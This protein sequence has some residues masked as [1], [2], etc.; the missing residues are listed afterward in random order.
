MKKLNIEIE[1]HGCKLNFADS[2]SIAKKFYS[3]GHNVFGDNEIGHRDIYILN[4]CTVTHVADSKARQSIRKVKRSNPEAVTIMTGCYAERD[5]D[6]IKEINEV[7]LVITN[8][9]KKDILKKVYDYFNEELVEIPALDTYPLIGRSRAS[10]KIQEGCNQICSYCIIPY[11]RGREKSVEPNEIISKINNASRNNIKEVVLT[12]TQLG[13]YGFDLKNT[14][15]KELIKQVLIK[16]SIERIR[17]SSLQP[18]EID[19]ELLD[20]WKSNDRLCPH[21]HLPLQSGSDQILKKMRRR[22]SSE[23]FIQI[24]SLIKKYL[25][26]A[27][28]TT[29]VIVGFP[30]EKEEDFENTLHT[31]NKSNLNNLHVFPYSVRPK[32]TAFY[33]KDHNSPEVI[34][35]RSRE[36]N[37]ISK[38]ITTKSMRNIIGKK[39]SILWEGK[40]MNSG[41]TE[42]YYRV[43]RKS[44]KL[45]NEYISKQKIKGLE[46][47]KLYI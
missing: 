44:V 35:S 3:A 19:N 38:L 8:K 9:E 1:T 2:Q 11:V 16:T 27:S 40:N 45:P 24:T 4:S 23:E 36:L 26:Q 39:R 46:K 41:L 47:D 34:K 22:Y 14:D 10:I 12:G 7:D 6:K 33:L 18:K 30:S 17:V 43:I 21:F 20:I 37:R 25:P 31:I 15:L 13:N 5:K 42:D 28:I 29:D 32:T